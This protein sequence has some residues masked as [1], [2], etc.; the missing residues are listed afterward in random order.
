M[1]NSSNHKTFWIIVIFF[2]CLVYAV[3]CLLI[4]KRKAY[5]YIS[6][7]SPTLLLMTN[8]CNFLMSITLVIFNLTKVN[9]FSIFFYIFRLL[10]FVSIIMR[11]ERILSCFTINIKKFYN[12]RYLLQEKFYVRIS[13]LSFFIFFIIIMI[14]NFIAKHCFE[15]FNLS[16]NSINNNFVK[17]QMYIWVL[18]NFLEQ[19]IIITYISRIY[20]RKLKFLLSLELYIIFLVSVFY[21]NYTS[22]IYLNKSKNDNSDVIIISLII[23]YIYLILNGLMPIIMSFFSTVN[24][25]YYYTPKLLNNL[26]L[27]LANEQCYKAFNDFLLEK[28]NSSFY[29]KLYTYIM[30][31]KLDTALNVDRNQRV[32]EAKEIYNNYLNKE[33]T[34]QLIREEVLIKVRDKCKLIQLNSFNNEMFDDALQFVFEELNKKF[35]EYKKTD[36]FNELLEEINLYSFIQCKMCNI[37]LINKY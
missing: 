35:A 4:I 8:F 34:S 10:M 14:I 36:E 33:T 7:R 21:S 2:N 32:N 23:L 11:Y 27:F 37:G 6:I 19:S 20:N 9:F 13:L 31:F 5:T 1:A 28:G 17:P 29:L 22:L 26:Y 24:I 16:N 25:S 12:K 15:I 3:C 18:F 30:K